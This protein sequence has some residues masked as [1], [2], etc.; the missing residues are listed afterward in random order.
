MQHI[1]IF[2]EPGRYAGWPANYGIWSWGD[3]IVVGFTVGYHDQSGGFHTRDRSRPFVAMQ[4]RSLDGGQSWQTQPTPCN[5]PGNRGLSADEHVRPDLGVA[6]TLTDPDDLSACPGHIDFTQPDFALMCA[7]SGLRA[8]AISWFYL[9]T[10]RCR[11]WQGP[12]H[13]P[14]FNQLGIAAR[15]DYRVYGPKECMLFLTATK[16]DGEEG[17]VFCA[18]TTDGG[19]TFRFISWVGPEYEGYS[20]MPT[21]LRLPNGRL[22]AAIRCQEGPHDRATKRNWLDLYASD[23]DGQSW[24]FQNQP[25]SNTGAGGNPPTLTRLQ[26]GR[27]CLTYGFRDASSGIRA[28]LS[29]DDGLTWGEEI[30][31]RNDGGNHDLGYPRTV[32]RSDGKLVTV[33]YFNDHPDSERY[34]AATLWSP[35]N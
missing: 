1:T 2:R 12:Y 31:L 27:L 15:T 21:S 14:M 28:K 7:R 20:I 26:D 23:D 19:Q 11:T 33:Y 9:S 35:P 3:E 30:V 22:L 5:T 25:V 10:D 16:P 4:A 32:Q 18:S 8:G 17:R 6:Q 24:T 34:L 29:Q 13:L